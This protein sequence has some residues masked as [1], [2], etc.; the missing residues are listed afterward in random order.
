MNTQTFEDQ[1]QRLTGH[2]PFHWQTRLYDEWF[3]Q[4]QLPRACGIPT[5]L[6]KTSVMA[7][8]LIAKAAGTELPRRLIYVVDRRA[9]VDQATRFAEQL[10]ENAGDV[11]SLPHLP[12]STLRGQ[13]TDNR[14]WLHDPAGLGIVVG[15]I[16][17]V[18]S[19]LLFSGYGVSRR[20]RPFHAGLLG[21]DTL[22]LLDEAHLCPPFETLLRAVQHDRQL[23][24][25]D[26]ERRS[27]VPPF[28][29]MPLTATGRDAGGDLFQ[30]QEE[31]VDAGRQP[32]A[33]QRY[34]ADKSLIVTDLD[35]PAK[36]IEEMT[37]RAWRLA[38]ED[39]PARVLIFCNRRADAVKVKERLDKQLKKEKAGQAIE[40]LVG[41][42]RV[43]ERQALQDWLERHGFVG[44]AAGPPETPTFLVA[45]SAGEVGVDLDADHLVC[46]LAPWERMVQRLGRVNRRGGDG[47]HAWI[48]VLAVQSKKKDDPEA[49]I[50]DAY[51]R[52]LDRLPT[53]QTEERRDA[54]PAGI[55]ALKREAEQDAGLSEALRQATTPEPLRPPLTRPLVE[56]W[57]LTSVEEHP[58]RPDIEPWLRGWV[59]DEPQ[60]VTVWRRHLPWSRGTANPIPEEVEAFFSAAPLHMEETLET[61]SHHTVE[62]LLQRATEAAESLLRERAEAQHTPPNLHQQPG[63]IVLNRAGKYQEAWSVGDLS[64][65]YGKKS[66]E[67]KRQTA[68]WHGRT[69]V[70]SAD[71]GGLSG[72]GML[73]PKAP[74][75]HSTLDGDH[76]SIW[77]DEVRKRIGYI[78][79]GPSDPAPDPKLW[80]VAAT[81]PLASPEATESGEAQALRVFVARGRGAP[82]AGDRAVASTAQRLDEHL[83]WAAQAAAEIA[84]NLSLPPRYKELLLAAARGHDLGKQR[85]LWQLAMNAPADGPYAKT[86]GGGDGRR[87]NGY[88]HEFGSLRDVQCQDR[89]ATL[90]EEERDLAL[91]LIAAHH[92]FA[93]PTITPF[94]PGAPPSERES[95]ARGAAQRFAGLQRRWG[96]WGLA[97]WESLLRA[98]DHRASARLDR[99]GEK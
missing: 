41:G 21:A 58:G 26:D 82:G 47:R 8:W 44:E 77:D 66:E 90:S 43:R 68:S 69:L 79:V 50:Q 74:P 92:G 38:T 15:T 73:D 49:A 98:A 5:G 30:L 19:R 80:K 11:L 86:T 57:S 88:R 3:S 29:L 17:M 48:E 34:T 25:K 7:I 12:V 55:D 78:P 31:E 64:D 93:R 59:D 89:L 76:D 83:E 35:D 75:H 24:P 46:D 53:K 72:D 60:T 54:S 42:R 62:V 2:P 32:V 91:H 71:L 94:D 39:G 97:W 84:D 18:G 99:E 28:Q 14:Q 51:R 45:T 65:L 1:F 20:M 6:G 4:G 67:K 33:H 22:V 27:I 85:L 95:L 37:D 87:L 61:T 63:L 13:F 16:D 81:V 23:H 40:L 70:V 56:A 36:L 52:V 96:P 9:V 10:R